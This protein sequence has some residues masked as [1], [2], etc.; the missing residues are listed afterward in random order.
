MRTWIAIVMLAGLFG[1]LGCEAS[2]PDD[3]LFTTTP[4]EVGTPEGKKLL[5]GLSD[6]EVDAALL[7]AAYWIQEYRGLGMD[8]LVAELKTDLAA[9][10]VDTTALATVNES[11]LGKSLPSDLKTTTPKSEG[12]GSRT[13]ALSHDYAKYFGCPILAN[14]QS[15]ATTCASLVKTV[16]DKVKAELGKNQAVVE[17]EV[18]KVYASLST[19][20]QQFIA[21]WANAAQV[22]GAEVAAVY[23]EHELRA[24]S[25]CDATQDGM[26]ISYLLGVQQGHAIVLE[27]RA[28]A[29]QQVSACVLNVDEVAKQVQNLALAKVDA[30]MKAHAVCQDADISSMNDVFNKAEVKRK[31]GIKSG[32]EQQT[33]IL[34]SELFN[35]RLTLPCGDGACFTGP[36]GLKRKPENECKLLGSLGGWWVKSDAYTVCCRQRIATKMVACVGT[37]KEGKAIWCKEDTGRSCLWCQSQ[38]VPVGSPIVLDLDDDGLRMAKGRV[39]FDLLADG[40]AQGLSWVGPREALLALDLDGNGRVDTGAELF[41]SST[42]CGTDRCFDGVMAL[43]QYDSPARGGN[44]DGIIDARDRVFSRLRLWT[45]RNSD[46]ASQADELAPLKA[47]GVLALHLDAAYQTQRRPGSAITAS[48]QVLTTQGFRNAYDLWFDMTL[49][50]DNLRALF[51]R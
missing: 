16:V 8:K 20:A 26:E 45:D 50:R 10:G 44:D 43:A 11:I 7:G 12:L 13:F 24:A 48:L 35:Y 28:W 51:P 38:S 36:D 42:G 9:K 6:D 32:I 5:E 1:V 31:E 34:R 22:Y 30:Y 23:A 39:T 37:T 14:G 41:G 17:A 4:S 40:H 15:P 46:G 49:G 3:S 19:E 29:M 47:R 27:L 21:A 33:S 25:K 2:D 18:K